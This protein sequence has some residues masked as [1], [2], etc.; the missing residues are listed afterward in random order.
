M[1]LGIDE[2]DV[3]NVTVKTS[4]KNPSQ[5]IQPKAAEKNPLSYPHK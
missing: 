4:D 2:S 1:S 5:R 3:Q